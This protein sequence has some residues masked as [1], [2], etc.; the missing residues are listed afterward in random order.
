[1]LDEIMP[2][3]QTSSTIKQK[4]HE[5][6]WYCNY[7]SRATAEQTSDTETGKFIEL[8]N[9]FPNGYTKTVGMDESWPQNEIVLERI[10]RMLCREYCLW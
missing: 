4:K 7:C 5:E 3:I 2:A 1:M 6:E 8:N 9:S 10:L